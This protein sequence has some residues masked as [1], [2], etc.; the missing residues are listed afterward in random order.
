MELRDVVDLD[1]QRA[2]QLAGVGDQRVV[3]VDLVRDLLVAQHA[4][5]ASHLLHLEAHGVGVLEHDRHQITERDPTPP[6]QRD[7]ARPELG[8]LPLV[9]TMVDDVGDGE[10]PQRA[11][12]SMP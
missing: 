2:R 8:T 11:H 3:G 7:D 4:L 5:G 12:V 9:R 1:E 6:L 10:L